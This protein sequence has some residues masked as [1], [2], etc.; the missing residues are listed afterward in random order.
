MMKRIDIEKKDFDD[1]L[2]KL[3]GTRGVFARL[4]ADLFATLGMD[5]LKTEIGKTRDAMD[6]SIFS[7][8]MRDAVKHFFAQIQGNLAASGKKIDEISE[9]MTVMY[10]KF[11]TEHGMALSTPMPFSL[12]RYQREIQMVEAVYQKQFGAA[13]LLTTPQ[14]VLMQKIYDSIASRV[15]QHYLLANRDVEAWLKVV[16]APL[17]AQISEHKNQLQRRHQ[18]IDRIHEA[19]DGLDEKVAALEQMQSEL[20]AQKQAMNALELELRRAIGEQ[21]ASY[22][23]AA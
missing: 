1:S 21:L 10:R 11:S 15:K 9:M 18:S 12:T 7:A 19:A 14:I 2:I 16:M 8:G 4:S 22:R 3:Q 6:K 17:D 20:D 13:A 5:V 23:D